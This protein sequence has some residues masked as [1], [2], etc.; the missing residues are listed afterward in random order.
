MSDNTF[1]K[2]TLDDTV[3]T[4]RSFI[5]WSAALGGTAVLAGG[6]LSLGLMAAQDSPSGRRQVW[7]SCNVNCGSR[8]PLRLPA[9]R[10]RRHH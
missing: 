8:C 1:L 2:E 3:L 7:S 9:Y 5:K 4:R 6:G 10:L